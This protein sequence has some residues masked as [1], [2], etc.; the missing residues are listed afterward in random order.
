MVGRRSFRR[1]AR[2]LGSGGVLGLALLLGGSTQAQAD[3]EQRMV[4]VE[5]SPAMIQALE[6]KG[7][8]VGF[9]GE[10]Y[11]A[12]VY[13]D[14]AGEARLRAEGYKIGET[15]EDESTWL[16]RKA[17]IAK[18]TER[19]A[20]AGEIARR[21][22]DRGTAKAKGAVAQPGEV[23]I[24]RAYTFTNY[25]G[26]FLYVEAHNANHD[27]N[28]GPA[29]SWAYAGADGVY[30]PSIN[31]GGPIQPGR[32]RRPGRQ[33]DPRRGPV[34]VPP[35]PDRAA[36]RRREPDGR[37]GH[38]ARRLEH[39]RLRH[40]PR[41]RVDGQGPAA[42]RRDVPEGL[43]HEVH[44]SDRD[45]RPDGPRSSASSGDIIEAI[46]LPHKTDGYQRPGMAMMA[47]TTNPN[48]NPNGDQHA[49]GGAAVLEGPGPVRAATTSP[50]SSRTRAAPNAPLSITVTDGTWRDHDPSD[51]DAQRRH[52][53]DHGPGQG[54]RR[55]PGHRRR[56]AR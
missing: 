32:R 53:R 3:S 46:T 36:R 54:H 47:G 11:E 8:D 49:V 44:G 18:T 23:V 38:G 42:A 7:Y 56:P 16:A 26:R 43:H 2:R 6:G 31:F 24:M 9:V 33:Q 25:A 35:R 40:Q 34:H 37:T 48:A 45:L 50:P 27:F 51:A 22:L 20:L 52:R 5:H 28:A 10:H 13:V 15:L 12:G 1:E 30:R 55:Q 39:R 17:E 19:E 4:M 29:M 21:G 14:D 41:H